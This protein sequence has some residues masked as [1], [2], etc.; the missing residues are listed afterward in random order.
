[1]IS[2]IL[3]IERGEAER[4]YTIFSL[5]VFFE[6]FISFH[7]QNK[8]AKRDVFIHF[9]RSEINLETD[10]GFFKQF[11]GLLNT[12]DLIFDLCHNV[13]VLVRQLMQ[14]GPKSHPK[15]LKKIKIIYEGKCNEQI[16]N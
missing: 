14:E 6:F 12:E 9:S 2:G 11:I 15:Y 16:I 1:M 13:M 3:H 5:M 10:V 4:K 8:N 7:E